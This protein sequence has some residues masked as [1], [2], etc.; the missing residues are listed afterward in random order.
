MVVHHAGDAVPH[1]ALVAPTGRDGSGV[2]L[3]EAARTPD[4]GSPRHHPSVP[5]GPSTATTPTVGA[6]W[7]PGEL[8]SWRST[9]QNPRQAV[10]TQ[11][12]DS[13]HACWGEAGHRLSVHGGW[14]FLCR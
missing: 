13:R 9:G 5:G 8:H 10:K 4:M 2:R 14:A 6:S 11:A 3:W 12:P 7:D 1:G